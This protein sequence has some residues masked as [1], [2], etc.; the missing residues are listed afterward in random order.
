M[1]YYEVMEIIIIVVDFLSL[2]GNIMNILAYVIY[3]GH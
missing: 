3:K 1:I 2:I